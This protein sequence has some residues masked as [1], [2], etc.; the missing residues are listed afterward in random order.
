MLS[1]I[2]KFIPPKVLIAVGILITG[3]L[4]IQYVH[5]SGVKEGYLKAQ[6][7]YSEAS[8][9]ALEASMSEVNLA[10]AKVLAKQ[11]NDS[12]VV[13]SLYVKISEVELEEDKYLEILNE[14][15]KSNSACEQLSDEYL[16]LFQSIYPARK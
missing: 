8:K 13:S 5:H 12:K 7:E 1:L 6:R 16:R 14:A 10:L 4:G 2:T 9:T 11:E 3:Y 15:K